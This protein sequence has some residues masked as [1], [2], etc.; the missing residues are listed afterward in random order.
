MD[1][2]RRGAGAYGKGNRAKDENISLYIHLARLDLSDECHK[3]VV[4]LSALAN[5]AERAQLGAATPAF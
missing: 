5:D 3:A 4:W 2:G 1:V